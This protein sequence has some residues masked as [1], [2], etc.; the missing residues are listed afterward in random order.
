MV[1]DG[2]NLPQIVTVIAMRSCPHCSGEGTLMMVGEGRRARAIR[3][4]ELN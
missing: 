2:N 3:D 1:I 4:A